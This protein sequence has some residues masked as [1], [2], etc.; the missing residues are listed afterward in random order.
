[1]SEFFCDKCLFSVKLNGETHITIY[2]NDD[3]FHVDNS[4]RSNR[5]N[6]FLG[7][8]GNII[9]PNQMNHILKKTKKLEGSTVF[10]NKTV[11]LVIFKNDA[12]LQ[13]DLKKGNYLNLSSEND[14]CFLK[15]IHSNENACL[16]ILQNCPDKELSDCLK[17]LPPE[18]KKWDRMNIC[19]DSVKIFSKEN[20]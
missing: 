10:Y 18:M 5:K 11:I 6:F 7:F 8:D 14:C 15:I 3:V 2:P 20:K 13:K 12:L 9:C 1:M 17:L 19:E 4:Y 16:G